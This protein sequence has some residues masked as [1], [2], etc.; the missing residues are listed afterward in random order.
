LVVFNLDKLMRKKQYIVEILEQD[1]D[2]NTV[3]ATRLTPQGAQVYEFLKQYVTDNTTDKVKIKTKK[4]GQ[5]KMDSAVKTIVQV[6][7]GISQLMQGLGK[8]AGDPVK[9]DM[10]KAGI[11]FGQTKTKKKKQVRKKR[12]Y[13]RYGAY[14]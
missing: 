7:A 8:M 4:S 10:S 5:E 14:R 9:M 6:G 3:V 2:G 11:S 12:K 1:E 13:D